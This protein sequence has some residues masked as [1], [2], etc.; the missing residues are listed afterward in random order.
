MF[1]GVAAGWTDSKSLPLGSEPLG[2]RVLGGEARHVVTG[3]GF[4]PKGKERNRLAEGR[5]KDGRRLDHANDLIDGVASA[6]RPP[7]PASP[8]GPPNVASLLGG[9]SPA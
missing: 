4:L 2:E 3:E 8:G 9:R 6:H 1:D 5:T 7:R